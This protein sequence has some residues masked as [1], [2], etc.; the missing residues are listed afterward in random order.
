MSEEMCATNLKIYWMLDKDVCLDIEEM[1]IPF[2]GK[3]RDVT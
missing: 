1:V 2:N 3:K